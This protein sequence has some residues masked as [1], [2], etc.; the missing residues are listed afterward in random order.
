MNKKNVW[1]FQPEVTHYRLPVFDLINK[2][3][4][5]KYEIS[6]FGPLDR[7]T[8]E[9]DLIYN[10]YQNCN[11]KKITFFGESI[12]YWK[13]ALKKVKNEK[14]DIVII[15]V[16]PGNITS[17]LMP[18]LCKKLGIVVIG[19]TKV[20]SI[21]RMPEKL[22]YTLKNNLYKKY[23]H[24]ITYGEL[25]K[26]EMM[27]HGIMEKKITVAN[28]TIDTSRIINNRDYYTKEASRLREEYKLKN[29]WVILYIARMD[30]EKRHQDIL[31]AWSKIK[32]INQ[33]IVLV[34]A[35]S[36]NMS[37]YIN[38]LSNTIDNKRILFIGSVDNDQDNCWIA[39]SDLNLQLGAVGL[40]INQSMAFGVPTLIADEIGSDT[41]ILIHNQTGWRYPKGDIICLSEMIKYIYENRQEVDKVSQR[42][43]ELMKN[44]ITIENMVNQIHSSISNYI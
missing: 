5:H 4:N 20:H 6:V 24:F 7:V 8:S 15:V 3:F 39:A 35:G 28:N 2:N 17:W 21:S 31:E 33:N 44:K 40:A 42:S 19:W 29:K 12:T 30:K 1:F 27:E 34:I 26:K 14:P 13:S 23:D 16:I 22:L 9:S 36:G 25:S 10:F 37:D 11:Y 43:I 32:L 38:Q 41:E 18:M